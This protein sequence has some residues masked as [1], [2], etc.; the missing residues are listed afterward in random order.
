[1]SS[2]RPTPP[3]D[4]AHSHL[5][6]SL[7]FHHFYDAGSPICHFLTNI[8]EEPLTAE[9]NGTHREKKPNEPSQQIFTVGCKLAEL[10]AACETFISRCRR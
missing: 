2:Q 1:M 10:T 7:P 8:H 6:S 5:G 9:A 4:P 3:T